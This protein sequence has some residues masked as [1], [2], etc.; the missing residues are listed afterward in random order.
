MSLKYSISLHAR[1][2]Y[3]YL[4]EL[5]TMNPDTTFLVQASPAEAVLGGQRLP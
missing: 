2:Y 5:F 4:H 1:G 3:E